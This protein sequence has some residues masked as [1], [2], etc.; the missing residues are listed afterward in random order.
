MTELAL[1]DPDSL[2]VFHKPFSYF[3]ANAIMD[4]DSIS[5]LLNWFE[6]QPPGSWLK[7]TSTSN[8]NSNSAEKTQTTTWIS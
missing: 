3:T 1:A 2:H 5:S 7:R 4:L 6:L 8:T